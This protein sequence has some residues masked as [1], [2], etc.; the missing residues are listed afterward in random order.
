MVMKYQQ[1]WKL[2]ALSDQMVADGNTPWCIGVESGNAKLDDTDWM[3]DLMLR[4]ASPEKM[5]SGFLTNFHLTAQVLN[6]MEIYGQFS[7][8]DDYVAGG[9][10][11]VATTFLGM[12]QKVYSP[13]TQCMMHRQASFYI[14]PKKGEECAGEADFFY[15]PPFA[16]ADLGNPVLGAGTLYTITKDSAATRFFQYL[17]EAQAR[18]YGCHK[19]HFCRQIRMLIC[20]PMRQCTAQAREILVKQQPSVLTHQT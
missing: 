16:S 13:L 17:T 8:N 5:T 18:K 10:A 19:V 12:H 20:Q 15:F 14:F 11:S 2:I 1:R 6:A 7:R 9:A 4:T 3:E